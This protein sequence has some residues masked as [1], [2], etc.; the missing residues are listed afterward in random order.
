MIIDSAKKLKG[1]GFGINR[2]IPKELVE[3]RKRLWARLKAEKAK[4]SNAKLVIAYPAKLIMDKKVIQ[5]SIPD[6]HAIMNQSRF[7]L[8]GQTETQDKSL[9][10]GP[11]PDQPQPN[12]S[13]SNDTPAPPMH[14]PP[15]VAS[16]GN[17]GVAHMEVVNE[18]EEIQGDN[19]FDETADDDT[20]RSRGASIGDGDHDGSSVDPS[21]EH[22]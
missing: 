1:L 11:Q 5:D 20:G 8:Y 21:T 14:V 19:L 15:N 12:T 18:A 3:A 2:D 4:N 6:W 17:S 13:W 16:H 10:G 22:T 7:S 9:N